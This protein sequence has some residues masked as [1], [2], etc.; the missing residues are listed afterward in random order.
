MR[1]GSDDR[2]FFRKQGAKAKPHETICRLLEVVFVLFS[3]YSQ[4][5]SDSY[6]HYICVTCCVPMSLDVRIFFFRLA[7]SNELFKNNQSIFADFTVLARC[8]PDLVFTTGGKEAIENFHGI[9]SQAA[10]RAPWTPRVLMWRDR[11][12]WYKRGPLKSDIFHSSHGIHG[13]CRWHA[14]LLISLSFDNFAIVHILSS[15]IYI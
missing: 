3:W 15:L 9:S 5:M 12:G 14:I 6:F 13:I 8:A 10:V 2:V 4:I 11:L 7:Q 1:M